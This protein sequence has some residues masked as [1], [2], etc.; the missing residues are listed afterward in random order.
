ML[1]LFVLFIFVAELMYAMPDI[2]SVADDHKGN[3]LYLALGDSLAAGEG[4]TNP[5][6]LGYVGLL[7]R[8]LQLSLKN[9]AVSGDTSSTF[10]S[11]GQLEAA[12]KTINNPGRDV[13]LVT[14]DIGGDDFFNLLMPGGPCVDPS[15]PMCMPAFTAALSTFANNYTYILEAL[16]TA[17]G[18][19]FPHKHILVMTYYNPFSGTGSIYE[20]PVDQALLGADGTIDCVANQTDPTKIGLNDLITC[21]GESF[22]V[23]VVNVYPL[24][25]GKALALTHIAEG[26]IH[27]NNAGYAVIAS[28]FIPDL[29]FD[30]LIGWLNHL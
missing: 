8:L 30:R 9:L 18:E 2:Q 20:A 6:R 11:D 26:D 4:A 23:T 27:P 12:L 17:L 16:T 14:L 22:G 25:K 21:I 3:H 15:N 13:Q 10:I 29:I 5:H 28:A 24:F 19:D 1:R 7:D